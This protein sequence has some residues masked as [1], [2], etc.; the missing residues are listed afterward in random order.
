MRSGGRLPFGVGGFAMRQEIADLVYPILLRALDLRDRL[1]RGEDVD[2]ETEQAA[3]RGMLQAE[4]AGRGPDAGP[5]RPREIRYLLASWLDEFFIGFTP[6]AER[7]KEQ[8]LETALYGTNDRAWRPWEQ[9]RQAERV[10]DADALEVFFLSV[11]LG[12]RGDA[13]PEQVRAWA[14]A[15]R[16]RQGRLR[17]WPAPPGR[18][19][20]T[21]VPPLR[22]RGRLRR[23]VLLCGLLLLLLA[24]L[25]AFFIAKQLGQ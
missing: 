17:A 25:A 15:A 11:V 9:A 18:E 12:F 22:W 5:S 8:K 4:P 20:P 3:L 1:G 10:G 7:W 19:P 2:F 13:G 14:A 23:A 21:D 16:A 6:W 24:P